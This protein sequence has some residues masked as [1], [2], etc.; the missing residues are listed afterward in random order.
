MKNILVEKDPAEQYAITFDFSNHVKSIATVSVTCETIV[1]ITENVVIVSQLDGWVNCDVT[2]IGKVVRNLTTTHDGYLLAYNNDL[3]TIWVKPRKSVFALEEWE[4]VTGI[5]TGTAT[6]VTKLT[7]ILYPDTTNI[8]TT[9][10]TVNHGVVTQ[11]LSGGLSGN[12]YK[13]R[14]TVT[15]AEGVFVLTCI[16][17][18]RTI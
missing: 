13:V 9:S 14:C 7:N 3:R 15:A 8:A 17:P 4:I 5:G 6:S 16:Q 2:D 1:D 12:T 10:A 18:V 11:V